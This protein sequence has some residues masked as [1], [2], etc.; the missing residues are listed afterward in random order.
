[1]NSHS[2]LVVITYLQQLFKR[3]S[4]FVANCV[5]RL[6][7]SETFYDISIFERLVKSESHHKTVLTSLQQK[8]HKSFGSERESRFSRMLKRDSR[9][10]PTPPFPSE[11]QSAHNNKLPEQNIG[12][13]NV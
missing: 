4:I 13:G 8:S 11:N 12:P 2:A 5:A 9:V 7:K 3:A 1:M 6:P 10:M